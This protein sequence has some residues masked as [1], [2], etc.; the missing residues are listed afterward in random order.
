MSIYPGSKHG[1]LSVREAKTRVLSCP[2]VGRPGTGL[3]GRR[4]FL[5]GLTK[6]AGAFNALSVVSWCLGSKLPLHAARRAHEF[7]APTWPSF[8]RLEA[9]LES[10]QRQHPKLI[11]L[12][13]LAKTAEGRSIHAAILTDRSVSNENK[14]HVLMTALH[15]GIE[16]SGAT[17]VF[18]I[19]RWLLSKDPLAREILQKQIVICVPVVNP[20]GY[21]AGTFQ[22]TLGMDPYTGWTLEGPRQ[23]DKAPEAVAVQKVM[24][25]F[26]PEIHADLHGHNMAFPGY[27]HV[28]ESGRAY[29]NLALR[30]YHHEIQ[31][32][33]DEEALLEGY[34]SD[35]LEQDAERIFGGSELGMRREKLWSGIQTPANGVNVQS[36]PR[37]YAAIYSYDRYHTMPLASEIAWERSGLLRHRRLLRVGNEIWPGEY[38]SGYP[39]RVIMKNGFHM[40]TAYGQTAEQRRRSRVELWNKQGQMVHGMNNP[41]VEGMVLHVCATS[42]QAADQWLR[43]RT[44]KAFGEKIKENPKVDAAFIQE[45]LKG[46]PTGAGQWGSQAQLQL[47][48]GSGGA[49]AVSAIENGLSIRLRIPY[50]RARVTDLRMNGHPVS[51]SEND[52]YVT[53]VARG[54]CYVQI[55]VPPSKSKSQDL[56]IVTCHYDPGEKR[57]QGGD[58]STGASF[59]Q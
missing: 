11:D 22:N 12:D 29:S 27:Y 42:P 41:Q 39:T 17:S 14:E 9:Q 43:D 47:S 31:R 5:R 32:L 2:Q 35:Q 20:D 15:T 46:Y 4:T 44:L 37:I 16:R 30:P 28:E 50:P 6:S 54:F 18:H 53:W 56:F 13:I 55:N 26:Q 3:H 19:M 51:P 1:S 21:V 23:P 45:S 40:I 59:Q 33:M 7:G 36:T 48:G 57:S 8:E 49:E 10:W 58:W 38:Y 24:D 25:K 52:G 34:P